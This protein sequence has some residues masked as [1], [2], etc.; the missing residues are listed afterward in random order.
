[1]TP[2]L[3]LLAGLALAARAAAPE[4][5][6]GLLLLLPAAGPQ[7]GRTAAEIAKALK[8]KFKVESAVA[9]DTRDIQKAVDRLQAAR[10]ARI[11]A[12]PLVASSHSILMDQTRYLLGIRKEPS[13]EYLYR[14]KAPIG[15]APIRRVRTAVPVALTPALD[16]HAVLIEIVA[17]N[18]AVETRDPARTNAILLV[19]A[20][21][22]DAANPQWLGT[23][24]SMAEKARQAAKLK[25]MKLLVL[26]DD[27]PQADREKDDR[28]LRD[29]A[30]SLA[31]EGK[32]VLLPLAMSGGAPSRRVARALNGIFAKISLKGIFP[33]AR[34]VAW[35]EQMAE[36][37]LLMP[38]MRMFN[39][40]AGKKLSSPFVTRPAPLTVPAERPQANPPPPETPLESPETPSPE[41]SPT[42]PTQE[43]QP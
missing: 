8:S 6:A 13:D 34:L 39:E 29:A 10:A 35:T 25:G 19:E 41:P 37:G 4:R 1:M 24:Q 5:P 18:A 7:T 3:I 12:I 43:K 21:K 30:K 17:G 20:P 36:K 14:G 32:L 15:G 42:P 27:V 11:I 28:A 9:P 16:D 26:R 23:I 22:A 31:R 2:A 38:D 33:H 40:D